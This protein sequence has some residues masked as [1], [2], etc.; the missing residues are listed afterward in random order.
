M[1]ASQ[2]PA[3]SRMRIALLAALALSGVSGWG[4]Y[5][6]RA[7]SAA[8]D[9]QPLWLIST[10]EA[11]QCGALEQ[12]SGNIRCW[13][14]KADECWAPKALQASSAA[15][16]PSAPVVVLVHGAWYRADEAVER[17][18]DVYQTLRQEAGNRPFRCVIWSWPGDRQS[19]RI[20]P[21][22][23]M[24]QAYTDAESYYLA[25]WLA[26]L[27]AK[28]PVCLIGHSFGARIVSGALQLLAGGQVAGRSL[29]QRVAQTGEPPQTTLRVMLLAP[30][31]DSDWLLPGHCHGLAL[32]RAEKILVT[33]NGCDRVLRWYPRLYGRRGPQAMGFAGPLFD[34]GAGKVEVVNM[35]CAVGK[36]H[37]ARNYLASAEFRC[38][39]AHYAFLEDVSPDQSP[40]K[41]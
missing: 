35:S 29:P 40:Q 9:A 25:A 22:L 14:W 11:P 5:A 20:R 26:A 8:A 2:L 27:P 32:D 38:R 4:G 19:R 34:D 6:A 31:I 13:Q 21:D 17:G 30:A 7:Q 15:A 28:T 24:K 37:D 18:W 12:G 10:R 16:D 36:S 33:Q 39:L 3:A 41:P 23:Q 1:V